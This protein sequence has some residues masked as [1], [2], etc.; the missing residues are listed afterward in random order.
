MYV[1]TWV[2]DDTLLRLL[3]H[4]DILNIFNLTHQPEPF[5]DP[6]PR[7]SSESS[8]QLVPSPGKFRPDTAWGAQKEGKVL[9]HWLDTVMRLLLDRQDA[10]MCMPSSPESPGEGLKRDILTERVV[11]LLLGNNPDI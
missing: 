4:Y 11:H 6:T 3:A 9:L 8:G 1:C 5:S 2:R 7:S 10:S